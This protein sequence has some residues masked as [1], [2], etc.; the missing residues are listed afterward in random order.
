MLSLGQREIGS[1]R[2]PP[3]EKSL[4]ASWT[5]VSLLESISSVL[6]FRLPPRINIAYSDLG[7][8]INGWSGDT[9]SKSNHQAILQHYTILHTKLTD[10]PPLESVKETV[11]I[12]AQETL[13]ISS[14]SEKVQYS[15]LKES[16]GVS[17]S[18]HL[19]LNVFVREILGLGPPPLRAD[20]VSKGDKIEMVGY[21]HVYSLFLPIPF[22]FRLSLSLVYKKCR[23][24]AWFG[25]SI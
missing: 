15:A 19:Q 6:V 18:L 1:N 20:P 21:C 22:V 16:L 7:I 4:D 10:P 14:W 3:S 8:R 23:V 13:P 24:V 9:F 17:T 5:T 2:E 11:K 25:Y 12:S